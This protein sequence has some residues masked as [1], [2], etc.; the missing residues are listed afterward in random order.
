MKCNPQAG[1]ANPLDLL[2]PVSL[3]FPSLSALKCRRAVLLFM[4]SSLAPVTLFYITASLWLKHTSALY[5]L[6]IS[7]LRAFSATPSQTLFLM[8]QIGLSTF[9]CSHIISCLSQLFN[10]FSKITLLLL[11]MTYREQQTY[12]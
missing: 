2:S 11:A 6:F 12:T 9:L 8:T 3:T 5:L 10:T 4:V 1:H 7:P